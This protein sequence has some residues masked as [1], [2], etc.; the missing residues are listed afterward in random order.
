MPLPTLRLPHYSCQCTL[1]PG[2]RDG[3]AL[4]VHPTSIIRGRRLLLTSVDGTRWKLACTF[5]AN[6]RSTH[7]LVAERTKCPI[8]S[9]DCSPRF[10]HSPASC[11]SMACNSLV[12]ALMTGIL[13]WQSTSFILVSSRPEFYLNDLGK[14]V[15]RMGRTRCNSWGIQ[16][17]CCLQNQMKL[18]RDISSSVFFVGTWPN[19]GTARPCRGR[20]SLSLLVPRS[21]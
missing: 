5:S 19:R 1:L 3:N 16:P 8:G 11:R 7:W 21:R 17:E 13:R 15:D 12:K 14:Q 18:D 4:V 10:C 9:R 6:G 20:C 2:G